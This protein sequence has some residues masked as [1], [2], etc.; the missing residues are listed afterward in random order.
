MKKWLLVAFWMFTVWAS[1]NVGFIAA[2]FAPEASDAD[3]PVRPVRRLPRL[4][5]AQDPKHPR[6]LAPVKA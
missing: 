4:P 2:P 5:C 6:C 1:M 3:V